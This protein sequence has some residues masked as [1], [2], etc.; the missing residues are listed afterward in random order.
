MDK[1]TLAYYDFHAEEITA[2]Y[3]SMA[4]GVASFFPFVFKAGEKVLDMGAGTG[5]DATTLLRFGFDVHAVEPS[6]RLRQHA[7]DRHPEL[8]GR[9]FDGALPDRLP[10]LSTFESRAGEGAGMAGTVRSQRFSV[11]TE[12]QA[13]HFL[14]KGYVVIEGCVDRSLADRWTER[15]P[16][17]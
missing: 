2:R 4:G 6:A 16:L 9:I 3:E 10:R 8:S 5:R 12:E 11:L 1:G 14:E 7:I 13:R 15:P 17:P